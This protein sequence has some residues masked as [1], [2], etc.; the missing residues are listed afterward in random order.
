MNH[1][2]DDLHGNAPD[3]SPVALLIIDMINDLDF[4]EGPDFL[5]PTLAAARQ[6]T[7]LKERAKNAGIPVVY[8]NDN[9][10]KWRSNFDELLTHCLTDEVRG[11][12]IV[13]LIRPDDDDYMVLKP[14]HSAFYA[15]TLE[16]LLTYLQTTTLIMT[17]IAA[18]VCV[19]FSATDA[20]VRDL[21]LIIPSDCVASGSTV[22]TQQSLA[23]MQ[24][25]LSADIT[26]SEKIDF[27]A[28]LG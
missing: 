2:S 24:R 26:P 21:K 16:T 9:F 10:G 18:D 20:Y 27:Q 6:I 23:Y 25:V 22:N 7:T 15:T 14:K 12:P 11:K 19:Q 17:G 3:S 8:A 5:E 13:E 4:P 28:L 1:T